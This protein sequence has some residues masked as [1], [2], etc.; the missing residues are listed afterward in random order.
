MDWQSVCTM[1]SAPSLSHIDFL[2]LK[3]KKKAEIADV[4]TKLI[5]P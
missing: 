3:E 5:Q 4:T 1:G 2:P